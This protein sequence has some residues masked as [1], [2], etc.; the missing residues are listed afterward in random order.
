MPRDEQPVTA[1]VRGLKVL[2]AFG[3]RGYS[4][5]LAE[6]AQEI[7]LP[8]STTYRLLGTLSKLGYVQQPV[9]GGAYC[10]GAAVLGLGFAMLDGL[11]VR[12][13][14][15]PWLEGLFQQVE[16]SVN[17]S[18]LDRQH[19]E[20][21]YLARLYRPEV[22]SPNL[23]VGSR[24]PVYSTSPGWALAA[25]LPAKARRALASRLQADPV[26]V[27]WLVQ[28]GLELEGLWERIREDGFAMNDGEYLPELFAMAAPVRDGHGKAVAAISVTQLRGRKD[29][30]AL[31]QG[32]K[33]P[34]LD[35]AERIS[36]VL[37]HRTGGA[38]RGRG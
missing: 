17:L 24:L 21:I 10:L 27:Q 1:L 9:K 22:L 5:T 15:L 29:T 37:G 3:R 34:L 2:E 12:E 19:Q 32:L 13:A 4:L 11:E 14:S 8:K 35:C 18:V 23:S 38:V 6:V 36:A 25:H 30:Q 20:V 31:C 33:G 26:A 16:G 28:R 7:G